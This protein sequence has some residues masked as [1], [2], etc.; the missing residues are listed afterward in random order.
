MPNIK[1]AKKSV[2]TNQET[3]FNNTVYNS[4]VKNSIKK[5]EIAAKDKDKDKA[6]D[7]LKTAISNIDKSVS[8]GILKQN[9]ADR[10]KSRLNKIV[11]EME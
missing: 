4:R 5:V 3:A 8:K 6:T 9:T 10:K 1:S 2:R 11:K 7:E